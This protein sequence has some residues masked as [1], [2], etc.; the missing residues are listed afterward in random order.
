MLVGLVLMFRWDPNRSTSK[1]ASPP[2]KPPNKLYM[3]IV[4]IVEYSRRARCG[5]EIDL[6]CYVFVRKAIQNV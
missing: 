5:F 2:R 3:A 6:I 4:S 1:K